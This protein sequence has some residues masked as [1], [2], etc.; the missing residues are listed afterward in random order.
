VPRASYPMETPR[1]KK[2]L[3]HRLIL[4]ETGKKIESQ[5][6]IARFLRILKEVSPEQAGVLVDAVLERGIPI[7]VDSTSSIMS[8]SRTLHQMMQRETTYGESITLRSNA[9][10][11]ELIHEIAHAVPTNKHPGNFPVPK[12]QSINLEGSEEEIVRQLKENFFLDEACS[13]AQELELDVALRKKSIPIES[14][15]ITAELRELYADEGVA[16]IF[17]NFSTMMP[18]Y[19][20]YYD[21]AA[22]ELVPI[23]KENRAA[24]KTLD[25]QEFGPTD[26]KITVRPDELIATF[27]DEEGRR[28]AS[29]AFGNAALD[30]LESYKEKLKVTAQKSKE[31]EPQNSGLENLS[32]G[33]RSEPVDSRS[34][35]ILGHSAATCHAVNI[36]GTFHELVRYIHESMTE[37]NAHG[38]Y[39]DALLLEAESSF[40]A[41]T[42][43]LYKKLAAYVESE[44]EGG[45]MHLGLL[46]RLGLSLLRSG[47]VEEGRSL[48]EK[49]IEQICTGLGGENQRTIFRD[50]LLSLHE[51]DLAGRIH[52]SREP[53]IPRGFSEE[54]SHIGKLA[55][56]TPAEKSLFFQEWETS[57]QK[58]CGELEV[59]NFCEVDRVGPESVAF[60]SYS[61]A[62][63]SVKDS[64]FYCKE[65]LAMAKA[66][67]AFGEPEDKEKALAV[68]GMLPEATTE[69]QNPHLVA[70]PSTKVFEKQT[71]GIDVSSTFNQSVFKVSALVQG[72]TLAPERATEWLLHA[73]ELN[74]SIRSNPQEDDYI[75]I[76][77]KAR[78]ASELCSALFQH[79]E[80]SKGLK[81]Y[82]ELEHSLQRT[83]G[84]Y[85][86]ELERLLS[87]GLPAHEILKE[88]LTLTNTLE[89]VTFL[90]R[91]HASVLKMDLAEA[92]NSFGETA[93]AVGYV[94]S[95]KADAA[96]DISQRKNN[97]DVHD[98]ILSASSLIRTADFESEGFE[99]F[100]LASKKLAIQRGS[101]DLTSHGV[102]FFAEE[103]M[104]TR[105]ETAQKDVILEQLLLEVVP[106]DTGSW[107]QMSDLLPG[108][109][110]LAD[111]VFG[112]G[113][114]RAELQLLKLFD[115]SIRQINFD[116]SSASAPTTMSVVAG[117]YERLLRFN[118]EITYPANFELLVSLSEATPYQDNLRSLQRDTAREFYRGPITD[119][120]FFNL[121]RVKTGLYEPEEAAHAA[122]E[123]LQRVLAT[124]NLANERLEHLLEV[125]SYLI[126]QELIRLSSAKADQSPLMLQDIRAAPTLQPLLRL[127]EEK[128]FNGDTLTARETRIVETLLSARSKAESNLKKD[129]YWSILK[130][131]AAS[132]LVKEIAFEN[133][134]TSGRFRR[135]TQRCFETVR[136][137]EDNEAMERFSRCIVEL[138]KGKHPLLYGPES[139]QLLAFLMENFDDADELVS[140]ILEKKT[141]ARD[142]LW[143]EADIASKEEFGRVWN[144][145]LG[146]S[147]SWAPDLLSGHDIELAYFKSR[148][149]TSIHFETYLCALTY[150]YDDESYNYHG[151]NR[152]VFHGTRGDGTVLSDHM[153]ALHRVFGPHTLTAAEKKEF[154]VLLDT[155]KIENQRRTDESKKESVRLPVIIERQPPVVQFVLTEYFG[156]LPFGERSDLLKE[157]ESTET[158]LTSAQTLRRFFELTGTE[159]IGQFLSIRRDILPEEYCLELAQFQERVEGST[160]EEIR[161]TVETDLGRPL[162]E[163]FQELDREPLNVGTV[164]QVHKA[165]LK[166]G[167]ICVVK[168]IPSEKVESINRMLGRLK[169][170]CERLE[171]NKRRF[172]GA[173]SPVSMYEEFARSM[174]EEIDFR[175]ELKNAE[176]IARNLP[177][178]VSTPRYHSDLVTRSVAVQSFVQGTRLDELQKASDKQRTIDLLGSMLVS[179]ITE[180]GEFH[181]DLHPGNLRAQVETGGV[182]VMDFGRIGHLNTAERENL[183]PLLMAMRS[184]STKDVVRIFQAVG[185]PAGE[186]DLFG[187]QR[188]LE[189]VMRS[190]EEDTTVRM[191]RVFS[192]CG[193]HGL[194]VP[195]GYLQVLKAVMTFEGT[196]RQLNPEFNLQTFLQ[197]AVLKKKLGKVG[198]LA[199]KLFK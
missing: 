185:T 11:F 46:R 168:V 96:K 38:Y 78:A 191:S 115:D 73:Y 59:L 156:Q 155:L 21:T 20:S 54:V 113:Y 146:K 47:Y 190:G 55:S 85:T 92:L 179:Q 123:E 24:E 65:R 104:K 44:K 119:D 40:G 34:E 79:G 139:D 36:G 137:M 157:F 127:V 147:E 22:R 180:T 13:L 95:F 70:R 8:L 197:A 181:D 124:E 171:R 14:E 51:K 173:Y 175:N 83:H 126:P 15:K 72:S 84:Y 165:V 105:L 10:I 12:F 87:N 60:P 151:K 143:K 5:E 128:L 23:L 110:A 62:L 26:G 136:A 53:W 121:D 7:R 182:I 25:W 103:V 56:L 154:R 167:E 94:H 28:K 3:P 1:I 4:E 19:E 16:G 142:P 145:A 74:E 183:I 109:L 195:S 176:S 9:S 189:Q 187:L 77:A 102:A 134:C 122:S 6:D 193:K 37:S 188:T 158:T 64:H 75:S 61:K 41:H 57:L 91:Q 52:I 120:G 68:I 196:A 132:A 49:H 2:E 108:F 97:F 107:L 160:F 125:Y 100:A 184:K 150:L 45:L 29:R 133:L 76:V 192:E 39:F 80:V 18:W 194:A 152:A 138:S 186:V 88:K 106:H 159:K 30:V 101:K 89:A 116:T 144:E 163:V 67:L 164:G 114:V 35:N 130:E 149:F 98:I 112:K 178:K 81:L 174:R 131:P 32:L 42:N 71:G 177:D 199:A 69:F 33:P 140:T 118:P 82:K 86:D 111:N 135:Y 58:R 170:V 48:L 17:R 43:E 99:L 153:E 31:S 166:S 27:S 117:V 141:V 50:D 198:G 169:Q 162:E 148:E 129:M 63:Y 172:P 161:R 93:A 66:L 90:Q